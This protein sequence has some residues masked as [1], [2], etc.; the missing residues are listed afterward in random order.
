[1]SNEKIPLT[2]SN[3]DGSFY[4]SE[5]SSVGSMGASG[6]SRRLLHG[7]TILSVLVAGGCTIYGS[8]EAK[9]GT[10]LL[11]LLVVVTWVS[12]HGLPL[13]WTHRHSSDRGDGLNSVQERDLIAESFGINLR[14]AEIVA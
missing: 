6:L 5:E 2:G 13:Q 4:T 8:V 9:L 14:R 11:P 10:M 1:M 3:G 7:L 12:I